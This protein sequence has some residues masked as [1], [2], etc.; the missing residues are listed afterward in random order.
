MLRRDIQGDRAFVIDEFLSATESEAIIERCEAIGFEAF[1]VEGEAVEYRNN[2]RLMQDDV[3]LAERLWERAAR[4]L[5]A[6]LDQGTACGFNPRF[7]FY[8]YRGDESFLAHYDGAV[9]ID[10]RVSKL[11][12]M[13]YLND[14]AQGGQTRFYESAEQPSFEVAP[15]RGKA[16]VF[17]HLILHEGVAVED[18]VKYVLRTD[19]MYQEK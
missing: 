17:D 18:G 6:S 10:D 3:E 15:Q 8:R 7:R 19:V 11:T 2:A 14:V 5:P 12:F 4:L 9:R 16:L 1:S 13:V